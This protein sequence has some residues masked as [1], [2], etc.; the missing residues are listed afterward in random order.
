MADNQHIQTS[1]GTL[2][3]SSIDKEDPKFGGY[4]VV[5]ALDNKDGERIKKQIGE[6]IDDNFAPK[7]RKSLSLPY[8]DEDGITV[9]RMRSKYAPK[10]FD[11]NGKLIP[12]EDVPRIFKG[13]KCRARGK[14][15]HFKGT[16]SGS[17]VKIYLG[18]VQVIELSS[19][20]SGGFD[21][22]DGGYTFEDNKSAESAEWSDDEAE[23]LNI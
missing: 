8:T 10:V 12:A 5:I 14:L 23:A 22:V 7:D 3:Y 16:G 11:A 21:A 19:D 13:S 2:G 9:V 4:K 17:G 1:I 18:A 20:T 15:G 6:F